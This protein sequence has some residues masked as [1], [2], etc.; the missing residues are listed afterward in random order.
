M[1]ENWLTDI[2]E[3]MAEYEAPR[4]P[5]GLWEGISKASRKVVAGW[6]VAALA[7]AASLAA[8]L[9]IPR[10]NKSSDTVQSPSETL[11]DLRPTPDPRQPAESLRPV[12]PV[13]PTEQH[14]PAE[15]LRP[16]E[17]VQ[18]VEPRQKAEPEPQPAEPE[19]E[20]QPNAS[21]EKQSAQAQQ[22]EPSRQS[23]S[24]RQSE[25]SRNAAETP[26]GPRKDSDLYA[27]ATQA[28]AKNRRRVSLGVYASGTTGSDNNQ[29]LVSSHPATAVGSDNTTWEDSPVLGLLA[30]N[31]GRSMTRETHHHQPIRAGI[32]LSLPLGERFSLESGLGFS[33]LVSDFRE[34]SDEHYAASSQTLTYLSLPLNAR[35][36]I[37]PAVVTGKSGFELYASGGVLAQKCITAK[38]RRQV[39]LAGTN[40]STAEDQFSSLPYQFSVG[41]AIGAQYSLWK[42]VGLYFEPGIA[43]YFDDGSTLQTIYK[44]KPLNFTFNIGVRFSL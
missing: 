37:Y 31:Q 23:E 30:F 40:A 11:A 33:L 9:L 6:G 26:W 4:E 42:N 7:V 12:E 22:A 24:S 14:Q 16:S 5:E 27:D 41:T 19:P 15:L 2:R 10:F 34:G 18:P 21:P 44:Q 20:P 28:R 25:P 3:R 39:V 36:R 32:S 43:Y 17:P 13:Q 1:S 38:G 35:Y 29:M 8:I